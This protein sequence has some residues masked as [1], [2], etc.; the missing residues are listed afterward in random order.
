MNLA[1]SG[2]FREFTFEVESVV[3]AHPAVV[4]CAI[5]G[6]GR[7]PR[8]RIRRVQIRWDTARAA[9]AEREGGGEAQR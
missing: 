8:R 7:G 3:M 4:E 6:P 2:T 5:T 1:V 9:E